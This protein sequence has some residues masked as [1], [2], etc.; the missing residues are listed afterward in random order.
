MHEGCRAVLGKISQVIFEY[1]QPITLQL[2]IGTVG[3]R[4]VDGTVCYG[5]IGQTMFN[6]CDRLL[7][8]V[9]LGQTRPT[10]FALDELVAKRGDE[11]IVFKIA[12]APQ[13]KL[14]CLFVTNDNGI[15][16]VES[17]LG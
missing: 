15:G 17:V 6:P 3:V 14:L 8:T 1:A 5:L 13:T 16:V 12:N 7:K 11:R 4:D 2:T 10:V 9:A